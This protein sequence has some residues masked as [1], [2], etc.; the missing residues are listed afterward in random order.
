VLARLLTPHE[1]GTYTVALGV[2][3]ILLT[4]DDLGIVKGLVRW[5]GRFSDVAPTARTLGLVTGVGVYAAAFA[6][7]PVIANVASTPNATA[8]IRVLCLGVLIDSSLQIVPAASLQRT[9]RQDLWV[10]VELSRIVVLATVTIVL[11]SR[12]VGVWSLVWGSLAGQCALTTATTLLS[13]VP[14][15]YGFDRQMAKELIRISAPYSLAALVS[16]CLLNIDYLVIGHRLG[17]VAVGIYLIAFNVSSW[18]TTLVGQ[19]VRAVSIPSF[20]QLRQSGGDVGAN[21]RRALV[22]LFAGAL[23]FVAVLIAMPQLAIATLY[24]TQ[25]IGGATALHFLALLSIVRLIDGLTDDVF[26]ACGHSGWI[27][28]KNLIW[29]VLLLVGLNIGAHF[30]GIRGVGIGHA[31]VAVVVVLPLI[32]YLLARLGMWRRQLL[33]VAVVMTAAA[34]VA[35]TAGW[36]VVHHV[37]APRLVLAALGVGAV[38][39]VYAGLLTPMRGVILGKRVVGLP[40]EPS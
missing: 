4:I 15:R 17:T 38:C 31:V 26:F 23:P 29:V 34:A 18:P 10:I 12:G 35:G 8:V 21:V 16:A 9:F 24:G 1:F 5:P 32:C 22:L 2:F 27:L 37:A 14:I 11:A 20:S 39:T 30:G 28:A 25:W 3:L 19:A 13:R 7:A 36:F 33:S 6:L 40:R